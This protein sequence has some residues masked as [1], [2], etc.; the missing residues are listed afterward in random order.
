ME[1]TL[2]WQN[3]MANMANIKPPKAL[4]NVVWVQHNTKMHILKCNRVALYL[5]A[6]AKIL[7]RDVNKD[8]KRH[9]ADIKDS[10]THEKSSK[11]KKNQSP[12][13]KKPRYPI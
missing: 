9:K 13:L 12:D 7:Q 2:T 5:S 8:Q 1:G 4:C 11:V 3:K 6:F 10:T